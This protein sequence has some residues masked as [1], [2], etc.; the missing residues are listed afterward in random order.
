MA[1][2]YNIPTDYRKN[3]E[4][5]DKKLTV[6]KGAAKALLNTKHTIPGE[7]REAL[8]RSISEY[9]GYSPELKDLERLKEAKTSH[10]DSNLS[11]HGTEIVKKILEKNKQDEFIK[12]WRANF[13][14]RMKPKYLPDGWS[15]DHRTRYQT[16][17]SSDNILKSSL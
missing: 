12:Q 9:L 3:F 17:Q 6:M 2:Q 14:E 8:M 15:V 10:L 11:D 7:R 13:L 4:H 16:Q 5:V 1:K